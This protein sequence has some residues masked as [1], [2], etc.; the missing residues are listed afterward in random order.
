MFKRLFGSK[1]STARFQPRE[2]M[3]RIKNHRYTRGL[4]SGLN[5]GKEALQYGFNTTKVAV[6]QQIDANVDSFCRSRGYERGL[7]TNMNKKR[8]DQGQAAQTSEYEP[9][10]PEGYIDLNTPYVS[11]PSSQSNFYPSPTEEYNPIAPNWTYDRTIGGRRRR[12]TKRRRRRRS[13]Y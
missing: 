5:R 7:Q 12:K 4:G 13:N 2:M 11:P 10:R 9:E 1:A 8:F 3:S 6:G